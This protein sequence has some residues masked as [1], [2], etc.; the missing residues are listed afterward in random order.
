MI[1]WHATN[2]SAGVSMVDSI[3]QCAWMNLMHSTFNMAGKSVS[4][5][6]NKDSFPSVMSLGVTKS[7]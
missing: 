4:L 5:I 6:V 2:L 3:V 1:I 7:H